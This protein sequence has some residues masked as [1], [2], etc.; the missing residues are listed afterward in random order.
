M[1][2]DNPE[3]E[4]FYQAVNAVID[5]EEELLRQL[6]AQNP[7]L[8]KLRSPLEHKGTLLHYLA[9][10]GVEDALQRT[11][12]NAVEI[13]RILLD[14]GAEVDATAKMY[15][16][17]P[18]QTPLN[19]LV[20]SWWPYQA[21]VQ[22][23]LVALLIEY[24]ANPNGLLNDGAPLGLAIGF[25][26]RKAAE[27]LASKG[28]GFNNLI[29]AAALGKTALIN[30]FFDA[31][32]NLLEAA[33]KFKVA[34][35]TQMG[36]FS[37]PPPKDQNPME[38]AFIYAC[39]HGRDKVIQMLLDKG[40]S[41]NCSISYNQT[42]L[43]YAAY[44]GQIPSL[45]LLLANGADPD[46]V[47]TQ[48]N[49]TPMDWAVEVHE[50]EVINLLNKYVSTDNKKQLSHAAPV[51]PVQDV[52]QTVEYYRDKLGFE[53]KYLWEDPPTYA[54][55]KRQNVGIH[56]SKKGDDFKPSQMHT[57]YYIFVYDIDGIYEE[58]KANGVEIINEPQQRDYGIRDFDI[59]DINGYILSFACG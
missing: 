50:Y 57:A 59:R 7:E 11:P 9:A 1:S 48:F 16:G 53:V 21:G 39:L 44:A 56:F 49:K 27:T 24:G 38:I 52:K 26:Y 31:S 33:K 35:K 28:A 20:S 23:A 12:P 58:L 5:G 14:A 46:Q 22:S 54:V 19:N 43:H 37:W 47:E 8:P 34:D 10:N 4:L 18:A 41:A 40:V 32:G 6:L 55:L 25:G 13:G 3:K 15:G 36:R 42:G 2:D 51:F 29:F 30:S 17:G 45:K